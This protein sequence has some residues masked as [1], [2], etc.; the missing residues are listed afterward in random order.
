MRRR[1]IIAVLTCVL[2][3]AGSAAQR[4]S[5]AEQQRR[6]ADARRE[7]Q[8]AERR[9][10]QLAEQA[11][12]ERDAAAKAR[13]EE[14]ALAS[15][16]AAAEAELQ[17]ARTRAALVEDLIAQRRA[18]LA[19]A[20]TPV[21]R[22]LAALQSLASRPAIVAVAQP[23]SVDDLVHVRAV[24]GSAVPAVRARTAGLRAE[25]EAT[26]ALRAAA[27][28]AAAALREGR[29][30]LEGA[31]VAL[32][33]AEAEHRGRAQSL[34]RD[35]LGES[36]RALAMGERARDLVDQMA[37]TDQADATAAELAALP[38]P[39]P[40]PLPR[41]LAAGSLPPR[42][43]GAYRLPVA[44]RLV[45]GLDEISDTGVRSRGLT[46]AVA[47]GTAVRAPADGVVRYAGRFR[48]YGVIVI[49]DH[50]GGWTSLVSGLGSIAVVV[51][52]RAGAGT[53]IGRA[54]SGEEPRITV[55]LRRRGRPIDIAALLD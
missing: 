42:N 38:G 48:S 15:R 22:L 28:T 55:E 2:L 36:D 32:A 8:A 46:L 19:A 43:A 13:A 20:Q 39:L 41:R 53:V 54:G 11:R 14:R 10:D 7:A 45:T 40:R 18:R 21:A 16:I 44:G 26:R 47:P 6:L 35:A 52:N 50:G 12:A 24:L 33:K 23:G 29:L 5:I 17:A 31:R 37:E 3:A 51:G 34:G 1:L 30:R 25:L 4:P 27:L 9:A 49:L